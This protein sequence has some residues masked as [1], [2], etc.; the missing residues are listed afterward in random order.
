M[1]QRT[2]QSRRAERFVVPNN[3]RALLAV[4]G[5]RMVGTVG[6]LSATG[7]TIRLTKPLPSGTF[8]DLHIKTI[9]GNFTGVVELLPLHR[10]SQPFRFVQ[11]ESTQQQRLEEALARLRTQSNAVGRF[12]GYARRMLAR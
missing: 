3:E 8:A 11:V 1:G 2:S 6:V 4:N 9:S 12:M 5:D 7:G 10:G